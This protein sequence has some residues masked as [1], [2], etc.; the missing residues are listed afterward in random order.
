MP[1]QDAFYGLQPPAPPIQYDP[2]ERVPQFLPTEDESV[3]KYIRTAEGI[4]PNPAFWGEH[5]PMQSQ[6][7]YD[8]AQRVASGA[9]PPPLYEAAPSLTLTASQKKRL[10]KKKAKERINQQ[11]RPA[12]FPLQQ[13][14]YPQPEPYYPDTNGHAPNIQE[15][16]W[17]IP[18]EPNPE[19]STQTECSREAI[20]RFYDPRTQRHIEHRL[21]C[22]LKPFP[23]PGQPHLLQLPSALD[24][25][26]E[27]FIGWY[28]ADE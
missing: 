8:H 22:P 12:P 26:T 14:Q 19:A 6:Q 20:V 17:P 11:A 9:L 4:A 5:Q 25:G 23:H 28:F 15:E 1:S 16:I 13:D 10:R 3:P 2:L 24:D 27:I 7:E 18:P 21:Q